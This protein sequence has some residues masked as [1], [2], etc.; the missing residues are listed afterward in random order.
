MR[1]TRV[2]IILV[3]SSDGLMGYAKCELEGVMVLKSI[4]IYK[5]LGREEYRV[6]Y[7]KKGDH[8]TFHPTT[9]EFSKKLEKAI[10]DEFTKVLAQQND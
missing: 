9:V 10:F 6:T 8:Y 3:K 7:P 2:S 1:I 5:K 4:G